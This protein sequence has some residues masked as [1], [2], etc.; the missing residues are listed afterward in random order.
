MGA[1]VGSV[2]AC[3]SLCLPWTMA[4][5]IKHTHTHTHRQTRLPWSW[6][7]AI[8]AKQMCVCKRHTKMYV[9]VSVKMCVSP[10]LSRLHASPFIFSFVLLHILSPL[11]LTSYTY[12][13]TQTGHIQ[14]GGEGDLP[15]EAGD[16]VVVVARSRVS[17]CGLWRRERHS[18]LFLAV[19]LLYFYIYVF[20]SLCAL[21]NAPTNTHTY[22]STGRLLPRWS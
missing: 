4:R 7:R 14:R 18:L 17:A 2:Y 9:R 10:L 19:S 8:C 5:G 3:V 22:T 12:K 20:T 15:T 16:L 13:G 6:V 11:L 21:R 1:C